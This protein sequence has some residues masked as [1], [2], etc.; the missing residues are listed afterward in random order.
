M[1]KACRGYF[2]SIAT[3]STHIQNC[4]FL[5][6][7]SSKK[8]TSKSKEPANP[9]RPFMTSKYISGECTYCRCRMIVLKGQNNP[10]CGKCCPR[11]KKPEYRCTCILC[12][13]QINMEERRR[14]Q[15]EC[16]YAKPQVVV[17]KLQLPV[18]ILQKNQNHSSHGFNSSTSDLDGSTDG[19]YKTRRDSSD[20]GKSRKRQKVT[21]PRKPEVEND[22]TADEPIIFDGTYTCIACSH[23]ETDR[24]KFQEHVKS[25]RTISTAYQCMEC[26]ECFV[27]KPSLVKHL[28]HYHD[29][30]DCDEYFTKNDCF[31][32][33]AVME[34]AKVVKAPYLA[35]AV[36]ENQCRVCLEQFQSKEMHDKHFRIHGMAFLMTKSLE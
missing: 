24:T 2:R 26:G 13:K 36:K 18:E 31:D 17:E 1:C 28:T 9:N 29:V 6:Y 4:K 10:A 30:R 34:L 15:K 7:G 33:G 5:K 8:S 22:L 11:S 23:Q 27:V 12:K 35:N 32:K 25:H 14:H 16:K 19:S 21:R 3:M 20:D